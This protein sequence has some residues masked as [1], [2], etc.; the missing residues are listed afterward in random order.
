MAAWAPVFWRR[1]L[2]C[3][4][5]SARNVGDAL[6]PIIL[7]EL[8]GNQLGRNRK[9]LAAVVSGFDRDVRQSQ[10]EGVLVGRDELPLGHE[11]LEV[12]QEAELLLSSGRTHDFSSQ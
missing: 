10:Q 11:A 5:G 12:G 1:I 8:F 6:P 3:G 9:L 4:R 2:A 7:D